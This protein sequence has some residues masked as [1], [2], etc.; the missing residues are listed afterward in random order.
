R[1]PVSTIS[2]RSIAALSFLT[3]IR[4]VSAKSDNSYKAA[5][6][7][8]VRKESAIEECSGLSFYAG[9]PLKTK[10]GLPLGM[11]CVLDH[12][13]RPQGLSEQ[14]EGALTALAEAVICQLELKLATRTATD[15]EELT[16]RL[17]ASSDDCIKV[18]DLKGR[19]RFLSQGGLRA[20]EV[21]D[22][23]TIEGRNWAD[24]WSGIAGNEAYEAFKK[25][26]TGGTGRFQ[27]PCATATGVQ[28]WWDVVY[29][30]EVG[31]LVGIV[32]FGTDCPY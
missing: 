7:G 9:A 28:K 20:M 13:A 31:R 22:F 18:F 5:H 6:L 10:D 8:C 25:A 32:G 17:L 14:Q 4:T 26:K 1:R 11:L 16:Q 29:A 23:G 15:S 2:T 24:L 12:E 27:G 19:L 30:S 3:S 21:A